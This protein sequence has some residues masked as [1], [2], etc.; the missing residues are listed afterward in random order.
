[1]IAS[2]IGSIAGTFGKDVTGVN[3]LQVITGIHAARNILDSVNGLTY[4]YD[5]NWFPDSEGHSLPFAFF[6]IKE[7]KEHQE[8]D[9]TTKKVIVYTDEVKPTPSDANTFTK[10]AYSFSPAAVHAVADNIISKP[11]TYTISALVP[12]SSITKTPDNL[13]TMQKNI[14]QFLSM[15]QDY[16]I[17]SLPMQLDKL[18][19]KKVLRKSESIMGSA[20][21]VILPL[22]KMFETTLAAK[23]GVSPDYNKYS[24]QR[25]A[26]RRSLVTF[27][28]W[29]SWETKTVA[30][31]SLEFSKSGTMDDYYECQMVLQE[32]PLLV[33]TTKKYTVTYKGDW[34]SRK[35]ASYIKSIMSKLESTMSVYNGLKEFL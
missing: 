24:L 18:I 8:A 21:N 25:M 29:N 32:M 26:E 34:W 31:K 27:K 10:D 23:S 5:P 4:I 1:M 3:N 28:N 22:V 17:D 7:I 9:I 13:Q 16:F 14:N 19:S 30:I 6:N 35:M 33:V 15:Y 11:K 2:D 12:Y 20:F